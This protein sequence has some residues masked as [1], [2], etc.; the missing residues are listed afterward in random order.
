[1]DK[2]EA[3]LQQM[4]YKGVMPDGWS[5]N[6]LIRGYCSLGLLEEPVRLLKKMSGGGLQPDVATYS[7]L[8]DYLL[9]DWKMHRS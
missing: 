4:F 3:V 1:M 5:Y 7:I 2:A 6:S 9:Q 8:I